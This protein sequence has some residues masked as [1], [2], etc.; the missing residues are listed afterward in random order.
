M[1][2]TGSVVLTSGRPFTVYAGS[3]TYTNVV[4]SPANCNGCSPDMVKTLFDPS[5]GTEFYFTPEQKALF[6]IAGKPTVGQHRQ[7][8]ITFCPA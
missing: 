4:Q 8:T 1:V 5:A 6:S 3:N 7:E 2:L